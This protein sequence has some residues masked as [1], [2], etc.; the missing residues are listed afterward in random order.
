MAPRRNTW[1]GNTSRAINSPLPLL[2][3]PFACL[4]FYDAPD[5][6]GRAIS[7]PGLA[8]RSQTLVS[9]LAV[10]S[11]VSQQQRPW[12]VPGPPPILAI[13]PTPPLGRPFNSN[14]ILRFPFLR[15]AAAMGRDGPRWAAM[16]QK[17]M[18]K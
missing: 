7:H 10:P 14:I 4:P 6:T 5:A 8:N 18:I 3:S 12:L 2:A 9:I 16:V 13:P 17:G 11:W 1:L 15:A